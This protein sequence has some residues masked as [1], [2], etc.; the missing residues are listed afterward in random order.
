VHDD[1]HLAVRG[2]HRMLVWDIMRKPA[3]TRAAEAV[4]DPL[5]GKSLV[6]YAKKS[7]KITPIIPNGPVV[8]SHASR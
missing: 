8:P 4:L 1:E 7:E 6:I 5:I 2:Y 3:L